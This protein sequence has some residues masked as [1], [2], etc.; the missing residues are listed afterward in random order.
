MNSTINF[1]FSKTFFSEILCVS[2]RKISYVIIRY[3]DEE[4]EINRVGII[5]KGVS[6]YWFDI[7]TGNFLRFS[8][9]HFWIPAK[10]VRKGKFIVFSTDDSIVEYSLDSF[11]RHYCNI[12]ANSLIA[13][14]HQH[15][16]IPTINKN[17][18]ESGLCSIELKFGKF[19]WSRLLHVDVKDISYGILMVKYLELD[20]PDIVSI[21]HK[22]PILKIKGISKYYYSIYWGRFFKPEDVNDEIIRFPWCGNIITEAFA[23]KVAISKNE[24]TFSAKNGEK[25]KILLVEVYRLFMNRFVNSLILS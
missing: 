5:V 12:V 1:V 10:V 23:T 13:D 2:A 17:K 19:F 24:V 6:K 16:I 18:L 9:N 4:D 3:K 15:S 7:E 20:T 11:Y 21:I 14:D 25:L 8:P 22:V